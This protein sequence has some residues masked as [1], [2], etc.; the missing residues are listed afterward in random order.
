MIPNLNCFFFFFKPQTYIKNSHTGTTNKLHPST[1]T[2][3]SSDNQSESYAVDNI[4]MRCVDDG[5]SDDRA[6][7]ISSHHQAIGRRRYRNVTTTTTTTN[8]TNTNTTSK[9]HIYMYLS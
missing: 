4:I 8:A 2:P 5:L 7:S 6:D 3:T 9:L 1:V